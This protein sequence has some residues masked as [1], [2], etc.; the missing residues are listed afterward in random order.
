MQFLL[1]L[2]STA[3]AL[4]SA[5]PTTF[6]QAS[7]FAPN[8]KISTIS[9]L[10]NSQ[11][12]CVQ[13]GSCST[14][15]SQSD[16]LTRTYAP[17][18]TPLANN[19]GPVVAPTTSSESVLAS[20]ASSVFSQLSSSRDASSTMDMSN[21]TAPTTTTTTAGANNSTGNAVAGVYGASGVAF[22]AGVVA[23]GAVLVA[24]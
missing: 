14:Q 12:A 10:T 6:E 8:P 21:S 22:A 18:I 20:V 19:P 5:S 17:G 1:L 4:T 3:A 23:F 9:T 7:T 16:L 15:T 11:A 24:V 13:Y 2:L